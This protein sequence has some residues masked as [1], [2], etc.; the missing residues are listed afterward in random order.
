M[1]IALVDVSMHGLRKGEW[2]E[3]KAIPVIDRGGRPIGL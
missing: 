3:G 2:I 1:P